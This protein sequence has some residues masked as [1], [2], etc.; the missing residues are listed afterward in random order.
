MAVGKFIN[1]KTWGKSIPEARKEGKRASDWCCLLSHLRCADQ[2]EFRVASTAWRAVSPELF[3]QN[4]RMMITRKISLKEDFS[5]KVCSIYVLFKIDLYSVEWELFFSSLF[6]EYSSTTIH[7]IYS[8][9]F[10]TCI[11][12]YLEF[13]LNVDIEF[14]LH[15]DLVYGR[16]TIVKK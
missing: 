15:L 14:C 13:I 12:I 6:K 7:V 4:Q 2:D 8:T 16:H 10:G 1:R 5:C 9:S 3:T 11:Y